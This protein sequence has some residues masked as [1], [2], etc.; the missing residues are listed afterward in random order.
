[1]LRYEVEPRVGYLYVTVSGQIT[2]PGAQGIFTEILANAARHG[3]P[4]ILLDCTRMQGEWKVEDR[5]SF[6]AF[7]AEQQSRAAKQFPEPPMVAICVAAPL[8]DPGRFTQVVANNRGARMR[9]S[10]SLHELV[11]WLVTPG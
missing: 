1:M 4:R 9:T 7:A 8:M 2:L 11:A 5:Y 6:G 10:E 3:Q